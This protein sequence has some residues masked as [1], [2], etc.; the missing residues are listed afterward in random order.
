MKSRAVRLAVL[1]SLVSACAANGNY[2]NVY[3]Q[4]DPVSGEVITTFSIELDN[5]NGSFLTAGSVG[6]KINIQCSNNKL[7]SVII[8]PTG[9]LANGWLDV[10]FDNDPHYEIQGTDIYPYDVQFMYPKDAKRFVAD[11][12]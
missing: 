10:K 4:S 8:D 11:V 5:S 12:L 2:N 3:S 7:K 6:G 1:A 9:G